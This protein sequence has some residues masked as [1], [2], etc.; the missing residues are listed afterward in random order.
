MAT[1]AT[2]LAT[3][4]LGAGMTL[5]YGNFASTDTTPV[6]ITLSG[7]NVVAVMV[8]DANGN[9]CGSAGTT[10]TAPSS[11]LSLT[12]SVTSVTITPGGA[13]TT[14]K[15]FVLHGGA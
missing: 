13:I 10:T 12:N 14:G 1:V 7:G 11:S 4:P 3:I 5:T 8:F 6:T 9:L 15:Y 2:P